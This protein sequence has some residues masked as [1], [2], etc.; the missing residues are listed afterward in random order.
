MISRLFTVFLLL[1]GVASLFAAGSPKISME[2]KLAYLEK[3]SEKAH[4]DL[5]LVQFTEHEINAFVAGGG[6]KLPAGVESLRLEGTPGVIT[7]Y[8]KVDF[9]EVRAGSHSM[10]PLLAVFSGLHDVVAIAHGEAAQG[11]QE[12]PF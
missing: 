5:R 9:D 11:L 4:P 6:I 7:S 8:A 3:N 12:D 1:A 2:Q 10:N